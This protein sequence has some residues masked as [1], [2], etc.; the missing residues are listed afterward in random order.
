MSVIQCVMLDAIYQY[1]TKSTDPQCFL[2]PGRPVYTLSPEGIRPVFLSD[3]T[4]QATLHFFLNTFY[5]ALNTLMDISTFAAPLLLV[6]I[7]FNHPTN[8]IVA[9]FLSMIQCIIC[10]FCVLFLSLS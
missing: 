4:T 1:K 5:Q 2:L 3:S 6:F 8:F 7:G 10:F 9:N